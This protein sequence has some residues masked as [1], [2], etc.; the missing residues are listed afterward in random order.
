MI[1]PAHS[2]E[3]LPSGM[4]PMQ[5][6]LLLSEKPVRVVAA[7][8]GSGKSWAFSRAVVGQGAHVLFIVPTKRLLQN[9]LDAARDDAAEALRARRL[10]EGA[11]EAW[12]AERLLEWSGNQAPGEG[13]SAGRTRARQALDAGA[14]GDGRIVFAIPETVVRLIAGVRAAGAGALEPFYFVRQF[15]HVVFDEFHTIDDR[16]FGLA[17]L[18]A[19]CAAEERQGK[20]SLLSATPIDV[21]PMLQRFGV[22]G[23]DIEIIRERAA[24]GR[25][26]GCRPIHG[27]VELRLVEQSPGEAVRRETG[28]LRGAIADGRQVVVIYDSLQRLKREERPIRAALRDAG[29][30]GA[31]ILS[32]NSIDDSRRAPGEPARGRRYAD[33]REY[34]VLLCTSSV[35]IG[36]TFRATLMFMEPGHDVSSFMQRVGRVA[37]GA[38]DGRILVSIPERRRNRHPWVRRVAA[39]IE[40]HDEL[41]VESFVGKILGAETRR[42][43]PRAGEREADPETSAIPFYRGPSWR[44]VYWAALFV[45]AIRRKMT[46]QKGAAERLCKISPPQARFVESRLRRIYGVASVDD[47]QCGNDQPHKRWADALLAGALAYR[48]IGATIMVVDP[49]GVEHT[50]S[51]SFLRRCTSLLRT[52]CLHDRDGKRILELTGRTLNDEIAGFDG[53]SAVARLNLHIRSPIGGRGFDIDIRETDKGTERLYRR[54]VEEWTERFRR[55]AP[56]RER[57]ARSPRAV[58]MGAATDL[59]RVLGKPPLEE[60]YEDSGESAIF[61]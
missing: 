36:V 11:I 16:A 14:P 56:E 26:P 48:D 47:C 15:D 60:D 43:E 42:L 33:P 23:A 21:A 30:P 10:P 40:D 28:A 31:R 17:C 50:V 35:E 5:E 27:D 37:R 12:L 55:G 32:I 8:T 61:A 25:P 45:A 20:V 9:L 22:A 59:V 24:A 2:V 49:G 13:E 44:G 7:P 1:V 38:D 54:I 53:T 52:H 46:V 6:R 19:R 34:D 4:S 29:L 39:A 58:V 51:E 57:A 3:M 18:L 41:D